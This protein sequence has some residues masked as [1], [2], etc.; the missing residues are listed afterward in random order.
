MRNPAETE[1]AREHVVDKLTEIFREFGCACTV[2]DASSPRTA[3]TQR[4]VIPDDTVIV[5]GASLEV[6]HD[7]SSLLRFLPLGEEGSRWH[8]GFRPPLTPD[9]RCRLEQEFPGCEVR[10][11]TGFVVRGETVRVVVMVAL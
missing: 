1:T 7:T 3:Q 11:A 8:L 2:L 5:I 6:C 10:W 9:Q 4:L